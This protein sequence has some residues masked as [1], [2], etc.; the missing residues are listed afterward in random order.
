MIISFK[1]YTFSISDDQFF[2]RCSESKTNQSY[3]AKWGN[4]DCTW[5]NFN[6]T[7]GNFDWPI[8][9]TPSVNKVNIIIILNKN[10]LSFLWHLFWGEKH[11]G[12]V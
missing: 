2:G 5:S 9:V 4:F 10:K 12:N 7:W 1:F 3:P 11:V 8:K 6:H